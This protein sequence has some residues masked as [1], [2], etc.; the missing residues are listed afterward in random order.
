MRAMQAV[1]NSQA[2]KAMPADRSVAGNNVKSPIPKPCIGSIVTH[3]RQDADATNTL[4]V[5]MACA[6][7][8]SHD[9]F[10]C[11]LDGGAKRASRAAHLE[12]GPHPTPATTSAKCCHEGLTELRHDD[13]T[14]STLQEA[15]FQQSAR[16]AHLYTK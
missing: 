5:Q 12:K 14:S 15:N 6:N 13:A 3:H 16:R 4:L 7:G 11:N 9:K 1:L 2:G 8:A 10:G